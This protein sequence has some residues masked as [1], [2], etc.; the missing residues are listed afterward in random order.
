MSIQDRP[1][2]IRVRIIFVRIGVTHNGTIMTPKCS[3]HSCHY[4]VIPDT[5]III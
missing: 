4:S 3:E 1:G 5:V 2:R